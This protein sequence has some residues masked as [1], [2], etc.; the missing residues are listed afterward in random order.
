MIS[1]GHA[2]QIGP[3]VGHDEFGDDGIVT[4]G[5]EAAALARRLAQVF[6]RGR[7][8]PRSDSRRLD[9]L[10]TGVVSCTTRTG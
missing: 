9:L 8:S 6:R 4:L 7:P 2:T 1:P 10:E 5:V 3:V